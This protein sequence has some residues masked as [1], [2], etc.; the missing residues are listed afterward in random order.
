MPIDKVSLK[1]AC[2]ETAALKDETSITGPL[3]ARRSERMT[4]KSGHLIPGLQ[5]RSV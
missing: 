3:S 2:R 1:T 5:R 4:P